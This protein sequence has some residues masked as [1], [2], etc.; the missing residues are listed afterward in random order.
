MQTLP[1]DILDDIFNQCTLADVPQF[2]LVCKH[3]HSVLS[4]SY[5]LKQK[6]LA[7][8]ETLAKI[9]KGKD[10]QDATSY[11]RHYLRYQEFCDIAKLCQKLEYTSEREVDD[12]SLAGVVE[13][14]LK[15]NVGNVATT[16]MYVVPRR[17]GK[18]AA[19]REWANAHTIAMAVLI[20]QV[21]IHGYMEYYK[22]LAD[23]KRLVNESVVIC[24][25]WMYY[26]VSGACREARHKLQKENVETF[27]EFKKLGPYINS[28]QF[29]VRERSI[30]VI[31]NELNSG[32]NTEI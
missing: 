26:V 17:Y 32:N 10:L 20:K 9:I 25:D 3:F 5:K 4:N 2:K 28:I 30:F 14:C 23:T 19:M 13:Q 16:G 11:Y 18:S 29:A 15:E 27:P 12:T 7:H 31:F 1:Y 8:D 22:T 24:I 6:I 21:L